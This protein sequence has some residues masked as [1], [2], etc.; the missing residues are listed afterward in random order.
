MQTDNTGIEETAGAIKLSKKTKFRI[1]RAGINKNSYPVFECKDS[2][3]NEKAVQRFLEWAAITDNCIAYEMELFSSKEE[4]E[5]NGIEYNKKLG[6]IRI[7]FKLNKEEKYQP[8]SQQQHSNQYDQTALIENA[9]LKQKAFYENNELMKRLEVMDAKL[10]E[11]MNEEDEDDD[12]AQL[13]GLNNPNI[14]NLLGLLSKALSGNKP[15]VVNG[16][17][18]EQISNINNAVKILS[19]YDDQIDTDLLKLANL[20]ENNTTTFE[21]LLKQL[22]SM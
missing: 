16:L 5:A 15:T 6:N 1:I 10:N 4:D 7:T 19:R 17:K 18:S 14:I 12:E 22:R 2:T 8:H 9:L 3:T 13:S 20:A 11:Y 21:F